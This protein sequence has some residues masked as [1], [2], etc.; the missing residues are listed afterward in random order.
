MFNGDVTPFFSRL[1]KKTKQQGKVLL[2]FTAINVSNLFFPPSFLNIFCTFFYSLLLSRYWWS[3]YHNLLVD[4]EKKILTS[5][6][7]HFPFTLKSLILVGGVRNS[8]RIKKKLILTFHENNMVYIFFSKS[9]QNP[10]TLDI[11]NFF[12]WWVWGERILNKN[13]QTKKQQ[14]YFHVLLSWNFNIIFFLK[15]LREFFIQYLNHTNKGPNGFGKIKNLQFSLSLS[16]SLALSL[17][18]LS[19]SLCLSLSLSVSLCLSLSL[20]VWQRKNEYLWLQYALINSIIKKQ[21]KNVVVF[22]FCWLLCNC[23]I[24]GSIHLTVTWLC[25]LVVS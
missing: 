6:K 24:F 9:S 20:S 21:K 22:F 10:L 12:L 17:S 3:W 11:S 23:H 1:F 4:F 18:V 7:L 25:A 5:I 15:I 8:L 13:K 19:L 2:F 16:V 14:Q